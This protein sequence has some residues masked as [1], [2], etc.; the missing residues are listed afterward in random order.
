MRSNLANDARHLSPEAG[1]LA[2]DSGAFSGG[3]DVLTWKS[4]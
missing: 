4:A 1:L 2:V 3:A